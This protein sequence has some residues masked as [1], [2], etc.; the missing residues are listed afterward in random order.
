MDFARLDDW[1]WAHDYQVSAFTPWPSYIARLI[2]LSNIGND[3]RVIWRHYDDSISSEF[4][5]ERQLMHVGILSI[6]SFCGRL[7]SGVGS[8]IIVK[9]LNM[10]RFWCLL[11]SS[12]IFLLA[13][14][15]GLTIA[16]PHALGLVS[17]LTGL[18]YGFLF[19]VY[20]TLVVETFGIG[21]L[22]QNWGTMTLAPIPFGNVFNLVY[23][24]IYDEHSIIGGDGVRDCRKGLDCYQ[25]AYL[26]TTVASVVGVGVSLWG[27]RHDNTGKARGKRDKEREHSREE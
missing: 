14:L 27:I 20:P 3:A 10:S 4:V 21:G 12:L 5:Q 1:Y 8:D 23:G 26:V 16:T 22:S 11:I 17:G 2:I 7:M 19:G 6:M 9:R 13:Q 25:N 24:R 18:A 15:F